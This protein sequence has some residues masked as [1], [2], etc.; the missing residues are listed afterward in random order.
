LDIQDITEPFMEGFIDIDDREFI[1]YR[2]KMI[3]D[4]K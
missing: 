4:K 3:R 2:K 1:E